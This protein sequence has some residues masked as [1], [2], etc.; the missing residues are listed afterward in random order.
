MSNL[1]NR[2]NLIGNLGG[3][4][5]IK[6]MESGKSLAKFSLATNE[7]YKN[8]NGETV[9]DTQWHKV[10]VFGKKVDIVEKYL[11]KGSKIAVDGR[12]NSSSYE[13]KEG[14]KKYVTEVVVNELL[15]LD[16]KSEN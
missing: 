5:E 15:L 1:K 7:F 8:Q 9:Q 3:A 11:D 14:D 12:L 13:T 10:V 2:V 6:K 4:P 16:P